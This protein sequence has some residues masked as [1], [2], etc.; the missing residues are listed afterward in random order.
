MRFAQS[1]EAPRE[2]RDLVLALRE[3]LQVPEQGDGGIVL[4]W[5]PGADQPFGV[6][7]GSL[8][9]LGQFVKVPLPHGRALLFPERLPGGG[10]GRGMLFVLQAACRGRVEEFGDGPAGPGGPLLI[11][12]S[13]EASQQ[14]HPGPCRLACCDQREKPVLV[15]DGELGDICGHRARIVLYFGQPRTVLGRDLEKVGIEAE[16]IGQ[17]ALRGGK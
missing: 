9:V 7:P 13:A 2:R 14:F 17:G 10:H 12:V 11:W 6:G 16:E 5:Q 1:R 8:R 15:T 3:F 4:G